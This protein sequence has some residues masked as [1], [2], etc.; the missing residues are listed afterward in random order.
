[1]LKWAKYITA[2]CFYWMMPV[3]S[4]KYAVAKIESSDGSATVSGFVQF[5]QIAD[6]DVLMSYSL[7]GLTPGKHGIHVHQNGDCTDTKTLKTLGYHFIPIMSCDPEGDK[8]KYEACKNV[9][10]HGMPPEVKRQSGDMGNID[11]SAQGVATGSVLLGQSKLSLTDQFLSIIG[12]SVVI[13]AGEDKGSSAQPWGD[14][15][16]HIWYLSNDFFFLQYISVY[17]FLLSLTTFDISYT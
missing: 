6:G 13:H 1:M 14:A 4:N 12:R 7:T 11:V 2:L 3:K 15:G 17:L 10:F 16:G 5:I 9:S 8:D